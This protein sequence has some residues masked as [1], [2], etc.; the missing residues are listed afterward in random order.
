MH[1]IIT[2]F[3]WCISLFLGSLSDSGEFLHEDISNELQPL[4]VPPLLIDYGQENEEESDE[5]EEHPGDSED[6]TNVIDVRSSQALS[7]QSLRE[8]V[9]DLHVIYAF[10]ACRN[11]LGLSKQ[12]TDR[13]MAAFLD[14][15]FSQENLRVRSYKDMELFCNRLQSSLLGE[16]VRRIIYLTWP[17]NW[18]QTSKLQTSSEEKIIG[19]NPDVFGTLLYKDSAAALKLILKENFNKPDFVK[20]SHPLTDNIGNR[21]Y[22]GPETGDWWIKI[23]V[24]NL[25]QYL[26]V[27]NVMR[28]K[29][30]LLG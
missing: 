24:W 22:S 19:H 12:D 26:N 1:L 4:L 3:V 30:F 11:G 9:C 14:P 8:Y 29:Y 6:D 16:E 27:E 23:E 2:N 7:H 13:I 25:F 18:C 5:E 20:Q 17:L 15:R 28:I 21:V 10:Q